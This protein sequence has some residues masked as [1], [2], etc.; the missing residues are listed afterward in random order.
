MLHHVL[1]AAFDAGAGRAIVVVGFDGDAV[2]ASLSRYGDRVKTAVQAER[3]GTGH[4]VGC[5]LSA[6]DPSDELALILCG[7]TPLVRSEDLAALARS[8]GGF[9]D[10][11]L[12]LLT[13]KVKD[14]T[15]YGRILR[16]GSGR[17]QA[18]REHRDAS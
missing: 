17:V 7:D 11:P 9:A 18:I 4:A 14:P 2:A 16:D 15:G 13:C 5:A 10:A 12:S 3:R 6:L 1:D 8:L